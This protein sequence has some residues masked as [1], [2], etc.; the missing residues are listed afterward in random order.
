MPHNPDH[1]QIPSDYHRTFFKTVAPTLTGSPFNWRGGR[2]PQ[3]PE[4]KQETKGNSQVVF[5]QSKG[6]KL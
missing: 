6:G 4:K 1:Q 5:E 3:Q 2:L